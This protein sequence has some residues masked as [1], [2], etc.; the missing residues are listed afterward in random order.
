MAMR[1]GQSCQRS[2]DGGEA[3]QRS[4]QELPARA[5]SPLVHSQEHLRLVQAA[6]WLICC[7]VEAPSPCW[8]YRWALEPPS[9]EGGCPSPWTA[10][11]SEAWEVAL[12]LGVLL[13]V[14]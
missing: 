1:H 13:R 6:S 12:G 3:A 5:P 14:P 10:A 9:W 2:A 4:P 8:G 11:A 7:W